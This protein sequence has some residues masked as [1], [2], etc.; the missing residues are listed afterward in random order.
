MFIREIKKHNKHY[1]KEFISHRLV[2]SIRTPKGPRQRTILNLGTLELPKEQWKTLA[3][4]IEAKLTGQK[5]LYPLDESIESLAIHYAQLIIKKKL[6]HP[7]QAKKQ[8]NEPA[9]ETIDMRSLTDSNCRT[10]GAEYVGLATLKKLGLNTLFE[11][12]G[13][14][15]QQRSVAQLAIVGRLVHPA[16]ELRTAEWARSLT[17]MYELLEWDFTSLSHNALYRIS[18]LLWSHKAEIESYLTHQERN[19]FS[20]QEKIILYDLTNTYFEGSARANRKAKRSRSKDKRKDAPLLTLA[21]VIDEHGFAKTSRMLPGNIGEPTTLRPILTELRDTLSERKGLADGQRL[22][23]VMDAGIASEE[24][25]NLIKELGY[26]Y[27]CVARNKPV[28]YSEID[29]DQL[30]TIRHD[31]EN[32]IEVELIRQ[33]DESIL[34]CKSALKAKKEQSMR[35]LLQERFEQDLHLAAGALTIKG[36]TKSYDK[37]QERIARLRQKHSHVSQYYQINIKQKGKIAT[38]ITWHTIHQERADERFSGTYFLRTSRMDLDEK[39]IWSL[40]IML[41]NIENAFR[42]LKSELNLRPIYHQKEHRADAHLFITVIAYHLLNAIQAEL[43][44]NDIHRRWEHIR[45]F[46]ASHIRITTSMT[47]KEGKRLHIRKSSQP[48]SFHRLIYGALGLS[49]Y[50]LKMTRSQS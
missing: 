5:S 16:S 1:P 41:T 12:L 23:V 35:K 8:D 4:A 27:V 20:L 38:E 47:T 22:T 34:F 42:S 44:K 15:P 17:A 45:E 37:V 11:K 18:D 49:Y 31:R 2:E 29:Q 43:K 25:L 26:D 48:E 40:Y 13:F 28:P 10:L 46:L 19:L 39:E 9:Y 21:L 3:N 24:N 36:G 32:K 14:T 7:A 6:Y 33:H 30:I 50:P